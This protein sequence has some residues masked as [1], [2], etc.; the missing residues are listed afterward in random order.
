MFYLNFRTA[1]NDNNSPDQF[2]VYI[3]SDLPIDGI[4]ADAVTLDPVL[5][6]GNYNWQ[7]SSW[8]IYD[9]DDLPDEEQIYLLFRYYY[10][11]NPA[12]QETWELD[13]VKLY[14]K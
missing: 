4:P 13:D 2:Q 5:S 9:K 11:G 3:A 6:E 12:G 7:N 1:R 10:D 14:A 8:L